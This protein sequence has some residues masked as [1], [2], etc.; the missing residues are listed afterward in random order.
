M[1]ALY[2]VVIID[3]YILKLVI[4]LNSVVSGTLFIFVL[5]QAVYVGY[6]LG[7]GARRLSVVNE[8]SR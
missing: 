8:K 1:D 6:E 2:T 5:T 4:V 3:F 7:A